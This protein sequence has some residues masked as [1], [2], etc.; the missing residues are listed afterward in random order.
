MK[1]ED[2]DLLEEEDHLEVVVLLDQQDHEGNLGDVEAQ[3]HQVK[4]DSQ[5]PQGHPD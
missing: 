5:V 2:K 1:G 3:E 4:E